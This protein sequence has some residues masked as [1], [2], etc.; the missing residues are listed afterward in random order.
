MRLVLALLVLAATP[1]WAGSSLVGDWF[2]MGQP[3]DPGAMYVITILPDGNFHTRHRFC[4][5]G[6][7]LNRLVEGSWAMAGNVITYHV[8]RVNGMVRPRVDVFRV[9]RLDDTHQD[10]VF[11]RNNF[12]Y[13]ARRVEAA[14]R[15]PS[16]QLVS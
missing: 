2:G 9:T 16:C 15:M 5:R 8:A 13:K 12:P 6:K 10:T 14:F 7:E 1:A 4:Q 11:L 3:W